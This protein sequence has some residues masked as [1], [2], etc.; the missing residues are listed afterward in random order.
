LKKTIEKK[1][2]KWINNKMKKFKINNFKNLLKIINS[3]RVPNA[4]G[5]LKKLKDVTI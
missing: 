5:G 4:K 1:I 3:K 2:V